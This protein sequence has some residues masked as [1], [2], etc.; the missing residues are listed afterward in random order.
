MAKAIRRKM[1]S[2]DTD[3]KDFEGEV[4]ESIPDFDGYYSASNMG[5]VK[6]ERRLTRKGYYTKERI[7]KQCRTGTHG[8]KVNL[9]VDG[10]KTQ[11]FISKLIAQMFI[12]EIK[13]GECTHHKNLDREDCRAKNLTII[14]RSEMLRIYAQNGYMPHLHTNNQIKSTQK[15]QLDTLGIYDGRE[16]VARICSR[17]LVEKRLNEFSIDGRLYCKECHSRAK[18]V[19]NPG[20]NI[21][22]RLTNI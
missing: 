7:L 14:P 2:F 18:G 20:R 12:K 6:S 1:P 11:R 22:K 13:E 10:I 21:K 3:M 5:R 17:C 4:W 9:V 19:V 16:L 8:L 15:L